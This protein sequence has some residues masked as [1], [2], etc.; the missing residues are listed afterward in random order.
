[1]NES[2][3]SELS[4]RTLVVMKKDQLAEGIFRFEMRDEAG[5]ELP[6]STAGAHITVRVP[7]GA[8]TAIIRCATIR[9]KRT[10]T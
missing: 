5:R 3:R 1:M 10:A 8:R 4:F 6:P 9:R 7:N 2:A